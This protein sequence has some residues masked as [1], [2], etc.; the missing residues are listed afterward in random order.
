MIWIAEV[1]QSLKA[2]F[3]L[4]LLLLLQVPGCCPRLGG[5]A[6]AWLAGKLGDI[7]SWV[8]VFVH[9]R[10]ACVC[11]SRQQHSCVS[12]RVPDNIIPLVSCCRRCS[13][14][15]SES[16]HGVMPSSQCSHHQ[17]QQQQQP[18]SARLT[19]EQTVSQHNMQQQ[20]QH[21]Q[22]EQQQPTVTLW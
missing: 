2:M 21:E 14:I 9:G 20:Q 11:H 5:W 12:R 15:C 3:L 1:W 17:P 18:T 22:E 16:G 4:S 10:S 19:R 7:C 6:P 13:H 8:H